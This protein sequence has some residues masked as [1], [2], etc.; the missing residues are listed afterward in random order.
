MAYVALAVTA[1]TALLGA[2]AIVEMI[3]HFQLNAALGAQ[4][5]FMGIQLDAGN[6]NSWLGAGL[7]SLTGLGLFEMTRR[8]FLLQ[9]GHIQT[10]IEKEIKRREAL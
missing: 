8:Q 6:L 4:L 5:S 10:D 2:A 7:V 1:M 3:Y 9:W